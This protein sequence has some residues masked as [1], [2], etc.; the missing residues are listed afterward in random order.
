MKAIKESPAKLVEGAGM[1]GSACASMD[2]CSC[3]RISVSIS[4][5]GEGNVCC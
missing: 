2:I 1:F 5:L 4:G 3:G